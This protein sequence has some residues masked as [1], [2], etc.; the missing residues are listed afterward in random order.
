MER[1]E[2]SKDEL[3][4]DVYKWILRTPEYV[5]FT[6]WDDSGSDCPLRRFLWIKGYAGTGKT[7][8][9]IGLIRQLLY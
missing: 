6:N 2:K 9:M 5:A 3:L 7:M 1:I 4:D 8:L